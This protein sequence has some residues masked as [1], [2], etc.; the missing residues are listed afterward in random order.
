[1]KINERQ[2]YML[3]EIA[4]NSLS[5]QD[6]GK[7][8]SYGQEQRCAIVNEIIS[9]FDDELVKVGEKVVEKEILI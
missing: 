4:I 5:I 8:F 2:I 6:N 9:Q 3:L 7:L 1:M